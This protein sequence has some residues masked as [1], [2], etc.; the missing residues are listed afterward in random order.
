MAQKMNMESRTGRDNQRELFFSIYPFRSLDLTLK[1]AL[2]PKANGSL[3]VLFR[4]PQTKLKFS[5]FNQRVVA[6]GFYQKVAGSW[7]KQVQLKLRV[8][9]PG[10]K[11]ASSVQSLPILVTSSIPVLPHN[12][13][14]MHQKQAIS[15][16]NALSKRREPNGRRCTREVDNGSA[17]HRQ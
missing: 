13:P 6:V 2:A 4:Y 7:M 14:N 15:S 3:R 8:V 12:L 5:S 11:R 10:R 16:L 17:M 1:K 9:K